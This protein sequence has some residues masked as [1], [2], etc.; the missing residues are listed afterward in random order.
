MHRANQGRTLTSLGSMR[1]DLWSFCWQAA[2]KELEKIWE[3]PQI[4]LSKRRLS[5][6]E[7]KLSSGAASWTR[8][9]E[10]ITTS[11]GSSAYWFPIFWFVA[12]HLSASWLCCCNASKL[13]GSQQVVLRGLRWKC[14]HA[15]LLKHPLILCPFKMLQ[16]LLVR[17]RSLSWPSP[18]DPALS[19]WCRCSPRTYANTS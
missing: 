8:R 12:L 4:L 11:C 5:E 10:F 16:C 1:A 15:L 14:S 7:I 19:F 18:L 9:S 2:W 3:L 6:N 17:G 13:T